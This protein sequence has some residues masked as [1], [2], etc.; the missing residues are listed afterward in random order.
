MILFL[1]LQSQLPTIDLTSKPLATITQP[2]I[3]PNFFA[4]IG[5]SDRGVVYE[6]KDQLLF[7]VD[8]STGSSKVV[9]RH[10]EGPG[11]YRQPWRLFQLS[12]D[13]VLA[14]DFALDRAVSVNRDGRVVVEPFS[15]RESNVEKASAIDGIDRNGVAYYHGFKRDPDSDDSVPIIRWNPVTHRVD[16]MASVPTIKITHGPAQNGGGRIG[17]TVTIVGGHTY[18]NRTKWQALPAGGIVIAHP[19]PYRLEFVDSS[20]KRRLGPIVQR[21][22]IKIDAAEKAA[23]AR[24]WGKPGL[25]SDFQPSYPPFIGMVNDMFV[26]PT[27]GVW[28]ERM[29]RHDD[30]IPIYDVFDPAGRL[31]AQARLNPQS[32]LMGVGAGVAWII[33]RTP[34]DGFWFVEKWKIPN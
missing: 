6:A 29:R 30:S 31:V 27:G 23:W 22:R 1:A 9:G 5:H 25:D 10:G 11:E 3:A 17:N 34:D 14:T 33:R 26:T 32:R 21:E 16:T 12:A 18:P 19:V 20:G 13:R 15:R 7:L 2:F 8:F 4:P 28:I 24:E